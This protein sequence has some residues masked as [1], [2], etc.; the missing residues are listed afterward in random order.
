MADQYQSLR[1]RRGAHHQQEQQQVV[2]D[3]SHSPYCFTVNVH[4]SHFQLTQSLAVARGVTY[5]CPR[6]AKAGA[7]LALGPRVSVARTHVLPT[8]RRI[9]WLAGRQQAAPL[10]GERQK[11]AMLVSRVG[12]RRRV[13]RMHPDGPE[14]DSDLRRA[15]R[16]RERPPERSGADLVNTVVGCL[17]D[18]PMAPR[19]A[20]FAR[21]PHRYERTP[22]RCERGQRECVHRVGR[23]QNRA[24]FWGAAPGPCS[25][26]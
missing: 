17:H 2:P 7:A 9:W 14:S 23:A 22:D 5:D 3:S 4:S 13:G 25:Y 20:A 16:R 18:A 15:Q 19:E 26:A 8:L 1:D 11:P 21:A 10:P 6:I 24:P 12:T